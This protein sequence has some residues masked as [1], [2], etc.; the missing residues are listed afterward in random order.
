MGKKGV[1]KVLEIIKNELDITMALCG[2]RDIKNLNR[3]NIFYDK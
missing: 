2:E 3:E 1:S